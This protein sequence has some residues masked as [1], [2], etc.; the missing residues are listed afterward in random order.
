MGK[1]KQIKSLKN[2]TKTL[3]DIVK[4]PEKSLSRTDNEYVEGFDGAWLKQLAINMIHTMNCVRG[5]GLAAPQIG[6]PLR[7]AVALINKQPIVLV[8]P[9]ITGHPDNKGVSIEEACLS[10]PNETVRIDRW[11]WIRVD[12]DTVNGKKEWLQLA[13]V[14]AII[15]QHELDHLDG[16]TIMDYKDVVPAA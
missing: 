16:K 13:G 8:N 15:V 10:C 12:Y 7:I 3:L 4:Y 11:E 14:D 9:K 2:P 1:I 5:V 6:L